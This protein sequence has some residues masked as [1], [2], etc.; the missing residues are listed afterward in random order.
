MIQ[1]LTIP[2]KGQ[3]EFNA[4]LKALE[5]HMHYPFGSDSFTIDHGQDYF[6]FFNRLGL[7][8]FH[9]AM[10]QR[11]IVGCGAGIIR[12]FPSLNGKTRVW[13][14]CDLKVHPGHR[15]QGIPNRLFR[16]NL[17]WNFLRCQ[18]AYTISMNPSEGKNRVLDVIG[19]FPWLPLRLLCSLHFYQLT[20]SE[21][22]AV[23]PEIN[24]IVGE[25]V[26]F[27]S[28]RGIKEL[29]M[30]SSGLP[31]SLYHA[32]YGPFASPQSELPSAEG[33]YL[34]CSPEGTRLQLFLESKFKSTANAS[35]LGFRV[36]PQLCEHILSSDI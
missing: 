7:A 22:C 32:Q 23:L 8:H 34:F 15:R 21:V 10:T 33:A 24:Q 1:V 11:S 3:S 12:T 31:L 4:Q 5:A 6:A 28:L 20:F 17:P 16:K 25:E 26:R 29:V 27:L 13:Y 30:K 9:L 18:R 36:N 14:L 19:R 2:P 35:V